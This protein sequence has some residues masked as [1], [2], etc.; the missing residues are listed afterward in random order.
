MKRGK[1]VSSKLYY[2]TDT[3]GSFYALDDSNKLVVVNK[4]EF[5][6]KFTLAKANNTIQKVIKPMQRYQFVLKEVPNNLSL[7]D[8][9]LELERNAYITT[10]FDDMNT[11]WK[12]EMENLI[13]FCSQLKQYRLNL[14]H[15]LSEVDKEI[16]DIMHYIEFYNL[17]AAK[18]YKMYKMLKDCRLR[19]RKIKD[20]YEK[21]G[22]AITV[23]ANEDL[24]EKMK[25][26]LKQMKG[27]DNR[28][29]TPR[30]LTELFE[31]AS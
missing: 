14:N 10:R 8:D 3:Y 9:Y 13:S 11:D 7:E 12:W 27:L 5:A 21:V 15:M 26:A 4:E 2:I 31:E 23:L 29:Y 24:I 28:L 30:I 6:T 19:R 17:D 1:V 25:T 18:G 22:A 20:E 16:C